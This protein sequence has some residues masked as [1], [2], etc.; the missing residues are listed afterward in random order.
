MLWAQTAAKVAERRPDAHFLMIG[1][2][3]LCESVR[4]AVAAWGLE[5]RIHMPGRSTTPAL[6]LALMDLFLLTSLYEGLPNV[7]IEAGAMGVPVISTDVGGVRETFI[8]GETGFAV[9]S[10][11][12]RALADKVVELLDNEGW[13]QNSARLSPVWAE[14]RFGLERMID[15]TLDAY[16]VGIAEVDGLGRRNVA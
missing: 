16:G 10:S 2:G 11:H 1:D 12:P 4:S 3:P 13:C 9:A 15:E 7:L 8:H 5:G 6:A 14:K